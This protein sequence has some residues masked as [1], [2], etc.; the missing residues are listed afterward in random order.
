[1]SASIIINRICVAAIILALLFS[2]LFMNGQALGIRQASRSNSY[3]DL[4]F[5]TSRVHTIDLVME[6]WD[7][8]LESCENEEYQVCTAVIDGESINNAAIR[9]KGNTSLSSVKNMDSSRYSF[10]LEFDHFDDSL[11]YHGLD[12]LCLNN[13]I[14]DNTY[15]K[16]YLTYRLMGAFGAVAPLCSYVWITVNGDPWGLYLAVEAIED[17]FLQRNYGSHT[18]ELYKPD[19]MSMGGGRG[20]G[21]EFSLSDFLEKMT[22]DESDSEEQAEA[23][24]D[25]AKGSGDQSGRS[26]DSS[27]RPE[28]PDGQ[29]SR[30]G[31]SGD[32]S[33]KGGFGGFSRKGGPEGFSE[34]GGP[35]GGGFGGMG[36]TDVKLA[37]TDD[38]FDSY[39][40]IFDSAK[41]MVSQTDKKR[42]IASIKQM[43]EQTDLEEV[44]D[45]EEVIRY[46]VVHNFVVN[47]DSYTGTMVHN[48]YLHEGD[49]ILQMIPWDYNLAFGTFQGGSDATSSVNT[50]IDTPVSSM[51]GP[52]GGFGK[53][54]S[55]KETEGTGSEANGD[56][57]ANTNADDQ[58]DRPMWA[59]IAENEEYLQRY[60][61]L[62]S[63]FLSTVDRDAII[64]EA[65][66]LIA[67][68]VAE[69]PTAFCT[70]E[71]FE[72]AVPVLSEWCSLRAQSVR[73]QLD[74][75]IPSTTSGQSADDSALVD[76]S[77]VATSELGSMG[78]GMG[79]GPGGGFP[80][81]FGKSRESEDSD[82]EDETTATEGEMPDFGDM[83]DFSEMSPPDGEMPDFGGMTPPDGE[84]PDFGGMTP[85]NGDTPDAGGFPGGQF[86]GMENMSSAG[87][88][89]DTWILLGASVLVLIAGIVIA[90]AFRRRRY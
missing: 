55:D 51:G 82:D 74:G 17:S 9:A 29:T 81:G 66:A 26:T 79:G 88:G 20:N 49:G 62:F 30:D 75:T 61:R 14:Q 40:N 1:M 57:R 11:T 5:D 68:Y 19:S 37:Y 64:Q 21:K 47:G 69:D 70:A 71:D 85:P 8:F 90:A 23:S 67:P 31:S 34:K 84:M 63:E 77:H 52:M 25:S 12:K 32:F 83:P 46:F 35:G 42:L 80:G 78:G 73:G 36:S 18:G 45:I 6:D 50:P 7:G 65:Y 56:A 72:T 13:I 38:D 3:E 41:T 27:E 59:W 10:K 33:G 60:H 54:R 24:A 39:S 86:P 2:V 4:L 22:D 89:T 15:M 28:R 43:N 87:Y 48:Y 53:G 44:V 58:S 16:D 76:A